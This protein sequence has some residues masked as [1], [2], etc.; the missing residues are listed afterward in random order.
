MSTAPVLVLGAGVA[1]LTAAVQL[2][3]HGLPYRI[4]EA[5]P[6]IAGMAA[7]HVDAEGF[8]YDIGAHFI[9][10]RLAAAC[11][12]SADCRTLSGYGEEFHLPG[13][14][15]FRYPFGMLMSPRFVASALRQRGAD[16]LAK[17]QPYVSVADRFE[18]EYGRVVANEVANPIVQAWSGIPA[19][20]LA[21]AVAEKIPQSLLET[22]WLKLAQRLTHRAVACGYCRDQPQN[23]SVYHVYPKQ[24]VA[25]VCRALADRLPSPVQTN[26]PAQRIYVEGGKVVGARIADHDVDAAAVISTV[27]INRLHQLVTGS[28]AT[29][30]FAEF[31]FRSLVL[32]NLKLEGR[33]LLPQ[34]V[35]WTPT[36]FP[37]SG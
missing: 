37:F 13:G 7:S 14:R 5:G 28:V 9:T 34:T 6:R 3:R 10:N 2:A 23:A 31:R 27:P 30:R 32:V 19:D 12:I 4:V 8:S 1:G 25:E 20:Q 24:G 29:D 21:S 35:V 17:A 18:H 11:G 26:Q 33:A 22:L 15:H 36:G 16:L